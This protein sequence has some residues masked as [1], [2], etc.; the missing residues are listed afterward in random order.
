VHEPHPI[1]SSNPFLGLSKTAFIPNSA[2]IFLNGNNLAI[3]GDLLRRTLV[4]KLDAGVER[5]ELRTFTTED[6]VVVFKRE[7]PQLVA[8]GLTVLRAYLAVGQPQS[9][10]GTL[11][12]FDEWC[13]LVRGALLWLCEDD[14]LKTIEEARAADPELQRRTALFEQWWLVL[15]DAAVTARDVI[16]RACHFDQTPTATDPNRITYHHPEFRAALLDIAAERG[17]LSPKV[18]GQW[19]GANKNNVVG[20][21]G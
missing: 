6:P 12:G 15:Q 20:E 18:F 7:R 21:Y 3:V 10:G 19:L 4:G 11:D 9:A 17:R 16:A 13:R 14:P 2:L 8:A 5:P 1:G